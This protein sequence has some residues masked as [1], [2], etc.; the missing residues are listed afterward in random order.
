M[1]DY[2]KKIIAN[3]NACITET[4]LPGKKYRGKV[5]DT[6]D[7][8]DHLL[9][10]TTDRLSAFDRVL[11]AIPFKGK[12]LNQISAWWFKKTQHIIT[13]HVLEVPE[14]NITIAKKCQVF[15]VEFIVRNYATGSTSTSLWTNYVKGIREFCG[16]HLPDNLLKNQQLPTPILTPTTKSDTHDLSLSAKEILEQQLMSKEDWEYV[17]QKALQLFAFGNEISAQHGLILVDTKYEFGKDQDG[18]ILLIDE[19]HTPDSSR[20]WLKSTYL[21]RFHNQQ[22]PDNF[23]KET[24]RLWYKKHCD[25]YKDEKLPDAPQ[26]LIIKLAQSYIDLY[27]MLVEDFF[28]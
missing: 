7:L 10:Y 6:Y 25:P 26:E 19:L 16:H 12:V 22:E 4:N 13:N 2:S 11:T 27:E 28:L 23:D 17:S 18:N 3:L 21:D 1:P 5:R 20:Y 15:P 9:L 24:I 14:A 8:G